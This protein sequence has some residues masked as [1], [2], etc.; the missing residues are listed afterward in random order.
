MEDD[1]K[2]GTTWEPELEEAVFATL[3]NEHRAQGKNEHGDE[4]R[5]RKKSGNEGEHRAREKSENEDGY[6]AQESDK[7][8]NKNSVAK[9]VKIPVSRR[10]DRR[11]RRTIRKHFRKR[12]IAS[13]F[14]C[15]YPAMR[16]AVAVILLLVVMG[17]SSSA[18]APQPRENIYNFIT[19]YSNY[20]FV[21]EFEPSTISASR[22]YDITAGWLPEGM[23][24]MYAYY[25]ASY[26][27]R[28][29]G[30]VSWGSEE[31]TDQRWITL[32][33][34][35]DSMSEQYTYNTYSNGERGDAYLQDGTIVHWW[36][37]ER[38]IGGGNVYVKMV[39]YDREH[40]AIFYM[41]GKYVTYE[42]MLE[43][44]EGLVV[45]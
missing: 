11:G 1:K 23:E 36:S 6:R 24:E 18:Y 26:T 34:Y 2:S 44:A 5:I 38:E 27:N 39:W 30:T 40:D 21:V 17:M 4:C 31:E 16:R 8:E 29:C 32:D 41:S 10:M 22:I 19:F 43:V 45:R 35:T 28:R 25:N 7:N 37:Y 20:E 33:V 15:A 12:R 14:D 9:S 13:F 3:I 42:E